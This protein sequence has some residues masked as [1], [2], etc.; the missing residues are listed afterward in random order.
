M[1]LWVEPHVFHSHNYKHVEA[2]WRG[3]F[4]TDALKLI[5]TLS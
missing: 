2:D 1:C 5:A 4:S 3:I